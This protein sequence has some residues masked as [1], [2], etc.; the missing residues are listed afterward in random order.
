MSDEQCVLTRALA[1][2]TLSVAGA[3]SPIL[4]PRRSAAF[5]RFRPPGL[6]FVRLFREPFALSSV[7]KLRLTASLSDSV[8]LASL[9]LQTAAFE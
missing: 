1:N 9:Q 2:L 8:R 7:L 5:R 3:D 6:S 4:L